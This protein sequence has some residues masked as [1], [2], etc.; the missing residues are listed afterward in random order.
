MTRRVVKCKPG[1]VVHVTDGDEVFVTLCPYGI[2][3]DRLWVRE[4]WQPCATDTGGAIEYKAGGTRTIYSDDCSLDDWL[5]ATANYYNKGWRPSIYMPRWAS[6]ITLEVTG[7]RVERV[8][9]ITE[10]DALAE[11]VAEDVGLGYCDP[12][13]PSARMMFKDLW[14]SLNSPRGFGWDV[15]PWCWVVEFKRKE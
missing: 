8:C 1:Q 3:G 9:E 11:G 15:N 7:V 13:T 10:S 14:N 2:P 6:R 12:E 5:T 4:T